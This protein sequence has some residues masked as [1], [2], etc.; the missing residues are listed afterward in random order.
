MKFALA[1]LSMSLFA[2][3]Y[4]PWLN[5]KPADRRGTIHASQVSTGTAQTHPASP[6]VGDMYFV[7]N[8]SGTSDCTVGGGSN[9]NACIWN[10]SAWQ[11]M[12]GGGPATAIQTYTVAT[13]PSGTT[14]AIAEVTD[15]A[16]A[17]DCS[18]GGAST[19]VICAY[20][21]GSWTALGTAS[22]TLYYQTVQI[23]GSSKTQRAKLNFL[24]GTGISVTAADNSGNG[25]TDVTVTATGGSAS[26]TPFANFTAPTNTG[27][28]WLNQGSNTVTFTG[29]I[30]FL[31]TTVTG[32]DNWRLYYQSLPSAPWTVIAAIVPQPGLPGTESGSASFLLGVVTLTDGT[33]LK[34]F[35][36]QRES[37]NSP[38]VDI[39]NYN[40]V[41]SY[42][43]S[44]RG[45]PV[46]NVSPVMWFRISDDSTNWKYYYSADPT[47]LGW[48][49]FFSE[50]RN[51]FLTATGVGFGIDMYQSGLNGVTI[52]TDPVV[53]WTITTP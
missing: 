18:T 22:V 4:L 10:G 34:C 9:H 21:S 37:S 3:T 32:G 52:N 42:N 27:W 11:T 16:S 46:Q 48:T 17:S 23:T 51:S 13:L 12:G 45:V 6:T 31:T 40:S 35:D 28:S 43:G 39:L 41:T 5:I 26:Y 36:F 53:S 50:T 24:S 7:N 49:L 8:G 47:N 25:S 30:A 38:D 15:G 29:G 33:K 2:Q 14:G 44:V 1:L 19:D 20:L